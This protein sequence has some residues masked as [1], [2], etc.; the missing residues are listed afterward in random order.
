MLLTITRRPAVHRCIHT[1]AGNRTRAPAAGVGWLQHTP[2][3]R[4]VT[5]NCP[6]AL[7]LLVLVIRPRPRT[8]TCTPLNERQ[9]ATDKLP[10]NYSWNAGRTL[11]LDGH[12]LPTYNPGTCINRRQ[13]AVVVALYMLLH[14]MVRATPTHAAA[15]A[16]TPRPAAPSIAATWRSPCRP[17]GTC[18][19]GQRRTPAT[20]AGCCP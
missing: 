12:D 5:T 1:R 10:R 14:S 17:G 18:N 13:E 7:L 4:A 11:K 8:E 9:A 20:C 6:V 3:S 2:A 16:P 19:P 15:V